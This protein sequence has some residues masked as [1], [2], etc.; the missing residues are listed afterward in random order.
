[1]GGRG[2]LRKKA[3]AKLTKLCLDL[4]WAVLRVWQLAHPKCD[5]FQRL[6][7]AMLGWHALTWTR[8]SRMEGEL[9]FFCI[10]QV[11][12][13]CWKFLSA[14]VVLIIYLISFVHSCHYLLYSHGFSLKSEVN[15]TTLGD[16]LMCSGV[17]VCVCVCACKHVCVC[18]CACMCVIFPSMVVKL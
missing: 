12:C 17:C 10:R 2:R 6:S 3:K 16:L 11:T 15:N 8:D 1:M 13:W 5:C 14:H 9:R 18:I 7:F 4:L